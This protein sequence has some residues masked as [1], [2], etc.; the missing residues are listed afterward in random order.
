[1]T[2]RSDACTQGRKACPTPDYCNDAARD[3][4]LSQY[5]DL[6]D[7]IPTADEAIDWLWFALALIF[8][9]FVAGGMLWVIV[10]AWPILRQI[11]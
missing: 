4:A 7:A 9:S 11:I 2:C 8:V 3:R 6:T 1:M 10:R 5:L